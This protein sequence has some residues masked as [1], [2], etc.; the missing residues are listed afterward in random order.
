MEV[1]HV[2]PIH[3][4]GAALALDNLQALCRSCH[5]RKTQTENAIKHPR[6]WGKRRAADRL[7]NELITA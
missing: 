6:D 5:I 3:R 7:V 1:D 2:I 4:R